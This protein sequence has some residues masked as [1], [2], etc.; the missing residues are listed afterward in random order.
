[1]LPSRLQLTNFPWKFATKTFA[2]TR[3]RYQKQLKP[4]SQTDN[5][6]S[7][8]SAT[9]PTV[10]KIEISVK[11]F[12]LSYQD[13]QLSQVSNRRDPLFEKLV[14]CDMLERR[15]MIDI[16]EFYVGSIMA[17]TMSD[18]NMANRQNRFV[19][20]CIR[21]EKEGLHHNFTLRNTIDGLGIEIM[22]EL[23]NPT[24]LKIEVLLLERR[25]DEDLSYLIDAL[26]EYS[27]FSFNM[28]PVTH[29]AG[30]ILPI[31]P[32]KVKL[33][34][35]PW[36]QPWSYYDIKGIEDAW[37]GATAWYKRKFI[38]KK[39][40]F[41]TKKYDVIW[42]YRETAQELEHDLDVQKRILDFESGYQLRNSSLNRK[43]I[44]KSAS[45]AIGE[46]SLNCSK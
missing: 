30:K 3:T 2:R 6:H 43:R 45:G 33:K 35:P 26:P 23:Y 29:P 16:P 4:L 32:L 44:L 14:H 25:L 11:E 9:P 13:F 41:E 22:Y 20:I 24:L 12:P 28:E 8:P 39:D 17:V 37:T 31:N 19:G 46:L 10:Q 42:H 5:N 27:T 36:S 38:A 7:I 15:M 34:P 1:M 40:L 21:R 18:P